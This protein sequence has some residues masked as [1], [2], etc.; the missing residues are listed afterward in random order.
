MQCFGACSMHLTAVLNDYKVCAASSNPLE[1][2][3]MVA[4]QYIPDTG[5][6]YKSE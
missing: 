2:N 5:Q 1:F 4:P 6:G 3:K